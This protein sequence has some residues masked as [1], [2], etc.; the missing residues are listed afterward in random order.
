MLYIRIR[1]VIF[2]LHVIKRKK[3]EK[4]SGKILLLCVFVNSQ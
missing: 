4:K 3:K 1:N 2:I